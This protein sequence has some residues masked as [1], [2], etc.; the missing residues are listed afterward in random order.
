MI[1]AGSRYED[2]DVVV[3]DGK[4]AIDTRSTNRAQT[5][6]Y[7]N[8]TVRESDRP[9]LLANRFLGSNDWWRLAR[10]NPEHLHPQVNPGTRIRVPSVLRD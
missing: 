4:L 6:E 2:A 7:L 3:I 9:D 10:A 1:Y 5:F 8:Y